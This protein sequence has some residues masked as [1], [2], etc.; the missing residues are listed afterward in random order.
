MVLKNIT[1]CVRRLKQKATILHLRIVIVTIFKERL[2]QKVTDYV[3]VISHNCH[4]FS[5]II[6]ACARRLK[7]KVT[8]HTAFANRNPN[9]F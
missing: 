2:I 9:H 8:N 3:A 6:A 4:C 5:K 7:Q 1:A